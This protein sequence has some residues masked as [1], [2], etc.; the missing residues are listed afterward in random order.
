ML[1]F[2]SG[3]V[4]AVLGGWALVV[5]MRALRAQHAAE[6]TSVDLDRVAE[7]LAVTVKVRWEDEEAVRRVNDPGPLPVAWRAADADLAEPWSMLVDLARTWPSGPPGDPA[8]W[9][10]DAAG[11]AGR[12]GQ[13]GDVFVD[14]VPTPR[15][16]I[17]GEPGAGKSVLLIRLLQH[18][19]GARTPSDPVPVLFSL[20]SWNPQEQTLKT[21]LVDQ[22]RRTHP[23][24]R[25][26]ASAIRG[27]GSGDLTLALLDAG[28]ILPL[29]DGLDELSQTWYATAIDAL[30]R[31]LPA[32]QPIVVAC[33]TA[34]YR[35]AQT[36]SGG[37]IRLNGAAAI[38]LLSLGHGGTRLSGHDV[39]VDEQRRWV[40]AGW[41]MSGVSVTVIIVGL[42][43]G[44]ATGRGMDLALGVQQ[45]LL[46]S[47][48]LLTLLG[49]VVATFAR[50]TPA[51]RTAAAGLVILF[52]L[53]VA[54]IWSSRTLLSDWQRQRLGPADAPAAVV[55][56][57]SIGTMIGVLAKSILSGLAQ[58]TQ[59]RGT[60]DA[61]KV[62]AQAEL[63]RAQAD[64]LRAQ[65]GLPPSDPGST[66][67]GRTPPEITAGSS[68]GP[69]EG[70]AG[71]A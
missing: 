57:V 61:E 45:W 67:P 14:R 12:D 66:D 42:A 1:S 10:A 54:A 43:V 8:Q 68:G 25:A 44:A 37:M 26:S 5:A 20:S 11:L 32:K 47:L 46:R 7:K 53:S 6:A 62:R 52:S 50:L 21:W 9:P 15:L 3:L 69:P 35:D 48:I 2:L 49:A 31:A 41:L 71:A 24:L 38:E 27:D 4:A 13:I 28:R 70:P 60:A 58:F 64:M 63:L 22:L 55:A 17:L 40:K 34:S 33:R 36:H 59:S 23:T 19:I 30:N 29:F 51:Q 65:H 18:L 56:I 39:G 16:V